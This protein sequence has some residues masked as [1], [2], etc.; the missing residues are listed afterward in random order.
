MQL[1]NL[2]PINYLTRYKDT[3]DSVKVGLKGIMWEEVDYINMVQDR[4]Q[5]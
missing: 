4:V 2:E 1:S 5:R 3:R